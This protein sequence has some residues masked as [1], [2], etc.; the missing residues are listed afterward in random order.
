MLAQSFC[1]MF[2]VTDSERMI[3]DH[4][5]EPI[6]MTAE[7]WKERKDSMECCEWQDMA[8]SRYRTTLPGKRD[9]QCCTGSGGT[10]FLIKNGRRGNTPP[11]ARA[12]LVELRK[13]RDEED[14]ARNLIEEMQR[15]LDEAQNKSCDVE[16]KLNCILWGIHRCF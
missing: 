9:H 5:A 3:D 6:T 10:T 12:P 11:Y 1:S 4:P 7:T 8:L 14:E 13:R 15:N 16:Q 2:W